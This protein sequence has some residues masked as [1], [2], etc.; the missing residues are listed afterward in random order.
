[1]I[2]PDEVAIGIDNKKPLG[3]LLVEDLIVIINSII[4]PISKK[5][6]RINDK[7]KTLR[8]DIDN[9]TTE[10]ETLKYAIIQQ[11]KAIDG[12]HK[13]NREK[14]LIITG[15]AYQNEEKLLDKVTSVVKK[16][17]LQNSNVIA[18]IASVYRMGKR[19]ENSEEANDKR[20]I[21]LQFKSKDTKFKLLK[22]T[23][24]LKDWN[25]EKDDFLGL[26]N[27][28]INLDESPMTR[29]ENLRLR[30]ERNRLRELQENKDKKL[31]Y[32]KEN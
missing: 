4:A 13:T 12:I 11:Q 23:E 27:I 26:S 8:T 24:E 10:I 28:Y 30:T 19:E 16:M 3:E 17:G 9:N 22:S 15:V 31:S 1:M 7:L 20:K 5:I 6:D 18:D 14:N 25:E 29:N 32:T 21:M 2:R